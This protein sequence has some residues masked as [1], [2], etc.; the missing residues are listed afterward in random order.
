MCVRVVL[1]VVYVILSLRNRNRLNIVNYA[2]K[3]TLSHL[4]TG[5]GRLKRFALELELSQFLFSN[6]KGKNK[7]ERKAETRRFYFFSF[8][9]LL[10]DSKARIVFLT[11]DISTV[12]FLATASKNFF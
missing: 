8:S 9:S 2:I 1:L 6:K 3:I 4:A 10:S 11:N 5:T 12:R 7:K